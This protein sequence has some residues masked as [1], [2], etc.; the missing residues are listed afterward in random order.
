MCVTLTNGKKL[1]LKFF[2]QAAMLVASSVVSLTCT[3]ENSSINFFCVILFKN[4]TKLIDARSKFHYGVNTGQIV[5]KLVVKR[6]LRLVISVWPHP[7]VVNQ[8]AFVISASAFTHSQTHFIS[9]IAP[10]I[11]SPVVA[12]AL[13]FINVFNSAVC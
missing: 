5:G 7:L 4:F 1:F 2:A 8:K 12:V 3:V 11:N 13:S 10:A 9:V 6:V